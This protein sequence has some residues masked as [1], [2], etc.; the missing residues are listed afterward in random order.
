MIEH[1]APQDDL[2]KSGLDDFQ[3]RKG[4]FTDGQ[5]DSI[6]RDRPGFPID[7]FKLKPA[8]GD[9]LQA[10]HQRGGDRSDVRSCIQQSRCGDPAPLLNDVPHGH[11]D[12][13]RRGIKSA[14]VLDHLAIHT[15]GTRTR[16]G[17]LGFTQST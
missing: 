9:Q 4:E 1:I 17:P 7:I 15:D 8:E 16:R 2:V 6:C 10:L 13:W 14:I 12:H 3:A 5:V 11:L